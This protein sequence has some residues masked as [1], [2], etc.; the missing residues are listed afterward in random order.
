MSLLFHTFMHFRERKKKDS[1]DILT[2][3]HAKKTRRRWTHT[4]TTHTRIKSHCHSLLIALNSTL[5]VNQYKQVEASNP[6]LGSASWRANLQQEEGANWV[7]GVFHR[8]LTMHPAGS[9]R[10]ALHYSQPGLGLMASLFV[11][12]PFLKQKQVNQRANTWPQSYSSTFAIH[13]PTIP[14]GEQRSMEKEAL[15]SHMSPFQSSVKSGCCF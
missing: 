8:Q 9:G 15:C 5:P 10:K 3:S 11:S 12:L 4:H 13:F 7:C 2:I 1:W 6:Q 14:T